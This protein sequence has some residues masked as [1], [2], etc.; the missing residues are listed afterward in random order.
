MQ[1]TFGTSEAFSFTLWRSCWRGLQFDLKS[2]KCTVWLDIH[3]AQKLKVKKI[4]LYLFYRIEWTGNFWNSCSFYWGV[5]NILP[6]FGMY[7]RLYVTKKKWMNEVAN[8][9]NEIQEM[10]QFCA[11]TKKLLQRLSRLQ[12]AHD[13]KWIC[14]KSN[15]M[16][17]WIKC[18][19]QTTLIWTRH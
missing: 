17:K 9:D 8:Y 10:D 4:R 19:I 16:L 11:V 7:L 1:N 12:I 6:Y 5:C 15:I 18:K 13:K 2:S 14:F 3:L